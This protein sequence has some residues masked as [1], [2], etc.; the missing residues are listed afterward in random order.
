MYFFIGLTVFMII[1]IFIILLVTPSS[2]KLSTLENSGNSG[3]IVGIIITLLFMG[4]IIYCVIYGNKTNSTEINKDQTK[5]KSIGENDKT[6]NKSH[7]THNDT[8]I[9]SNKFIETLVNSIADKNKI[10]A[11]LENKLAIENKIPIEN[12]SAVT[13]N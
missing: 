12:N 2:K 9:Y 4:L 6:E 11:D 3:N 5:Q 13:I 7:Q 10:I 8:N 1:S